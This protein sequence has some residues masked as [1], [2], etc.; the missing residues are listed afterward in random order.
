M[1][2]R[3]L[4]FMLCLIVTVGNAVYAKMIEGTCKNGAWHIDEDGTLTVNIFGDMADYGKGKAPWYN[5]ANEI[6]AI[7]I[8]YNCTNIGR[9]AFYG[10]NKVTKVTGGE[11]VEACAMYSFYDVRYADINLPKCRYVGD[12]AFDDTDRCK[13]LS[14]PSVENLNYKSVYR[15]ELVDIGSKVKDIR[16]GTLEYVECVFI[17]NP[18]P[19]DWS[20]LPTWDEVTS[21]DRYIQGYSSFDAWLDNDRDKDYP[22]SGCQRV[23]V[24]QEYLN[25]YID[26]YPSKH[27]EVERGYVAQDGKLVAGAPIYNDGCLI[28]GWYV[29]D[30]ELYVRI[31]TD[32]MTAFPDDDD[33]WKDV[34]GKVTS[35]HIEFNRMDGVKIPDDAFNADKNN[36]MKGIKKVIVKGYYGEDSPFI[37]GD[38]AFKN[39]V[40]LEEVYG[41]GYFAFGS[42]S[43]AGCKNLTNIS[44]IVSDEPLFSITK[45]GKSCFEG[46]EKLDLNPDGSG[47]Y[48]RDVYIE[49][50]I[51]VPSRAF[52]GCKSLQWEIFRTAR[53]SSIGDQA[54]YGTGVKELRGLYWCPII[55]QES[56]A[57]CD[58]LKQICIDN[59]SFEIGHRAF[60]NCNKLTDIYGTSEAPTTAEDAF[61][62]V[63][64]SKITLHA[65]NVASYL[66]QPN[67]GEMKVDK[68]NAFP[69]YE[70]GFSI[71]AS[72]VLELNKK[73]NEYDSEYAEKWKLYKDYITEVLIKSGVESIKAGWFSGMDKIQRVSVPYSCKSI[74]DE[75]FKGCTNLNDININTVE[76][77]GNNVFEGCSSLQ[78]ISLGLKLQRAG[79]YIFKDCTQLELIEN[80]ENTPAEVTLLTFAEIGS[81][82]Y[83]ARGAVR[84]GLTS[85][86]DGQRNVTLKVPDEFVTNYIVDPNWGKFHI[87]FADSRG[88]WQHAGRFGDGTWIL[89]DDSTMVVAADKDPDDVRWST[90]G[91]TNEV[92]N[93]TKRVEFTGNLTKLDAVFS[94]FPN[95]E[96]VSLSPLI[97]TLE[98]TFNYCEKLRSINLENVT[99]IGDETFIYCSLDTVNLSN[100]KSIGKDAFY[101]CKQ[102]KKVDLSNVSSLGQEAFRGCEQLKTAI[103]GSQCVVG[104]SAF[105][106]CGALVAVNLGDVNLES[107][108]SC[109]QGCKSIRCIVY[110]GSNLPEG[111]FSDCSSLSTVKLGSR[112]R[113]IKWNAFKGCT[114]IDSI[115]CDSPLPPALPAGKWQDI[116]GYEGDTEVQMPIY[117]EEYDVWAFD[118]LDKASVRLFVNPDCIPVYSRF[119]IWKEMTIEGNAEDVEPLLP[120]G[121]SMYGC[122][123]DE[124]G[125]YVMSG[126]SWH[127][128]PDGKM[129]LDALGNIAVRTS[130]KNYWWSEFDSYLP[131]IASVEVTD[132]VTSVPNN[133]FGFMDFERLSRGVNTVTL[134]EGLLKVGYD[135]FGFSGIKDVYIYSEQL[136]LIHPSAF[137]LEAAVANSATL[138]VLKDPEDKYL[139][140]YRSHSATSSF[141]NIVAD[142]EPR[143]P[144]V[145]SV[146]FEYSEVTMHPGD[147]L[148]LEP[149]FLP[150]NVEDK[151]LRYEDVSGG[152]HVSID[153]TGL[154]TAMTEGVAYVEAFSSYTLS[155]NEMMAL[156]GPTEEIYLKITI[157]EP[158]P[159]EEIFYDYKEGEGTEGL[160]I[161]YHQ[162]DDKEHTCEVAGRYDED[163]MTTLAVPENT[164]GIINIP[165]IA[166]GNTVVRIG[167]NAF[168]ELE[169]ITEVRLPATVTQ[170]GRYAF[171]SCYNVKDVYIPVSQPL[172]YTDAYGDVME[173]SMGHNDAFYRVGEDVESGAT[174][175]VPAGSRTAWNIYPW[176]EWFRMIVDDIKMTL[177]GDVNGDGEIGMPDVMFLVNYIL[178]NP[179]ETFNANAADANQDGEIGMPDVMFI[180]QYILNGRFPDEE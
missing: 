106:N 20:R 163:D 158:E 32:Q 174:L 137:N 104:K 156:W 119:D 66:R 59:S 107:A 103:L 50:S 139:N 57:N 72:G 15:C 95:L 45:L 147:T 64:L 67:W 49:D 87:T 97:K 47:S 141:P 142:L 33:L 26:F 81:S 175:H 162:L 1:N 122:G 17:Q 52:Y 31:Y 125:N 143:H 70:F 146:T 166:G 121:G 160:T 167:A 19:P 48:F 51:S 22:F 169:G 80:K 112:V 117:G 136:L 3:R 4:L 150:D 21:W 165:E 168:Y 41:Y 92:C 78:Y 24:P 74:G 65:D 85:S 155:G 61:E 177:R 94:T 91:F 126:S 123:K 69:V 151:T 54:F 84:S 130:S 134:G 132:S 79:D 108:T 140:Y 73:I 114:A 120:T 111:I 138:H 29:E 128:D 18:I 176:N 135:S 35:M 34:I 77:L 145:Q 86:S 124:D 83:E 2:I 63:E 93:K 27:P 62:G 154:I 68:L 42:E 113:S 8:G 161:T 180:V 14:L 55:G 13:N 44:S 6:K 25:T 164:I 82:A 131:F 58:F 116:I 56:F 38:R 89:Y 127:L 30:N 9:F 179:A 115:Y 159:G 148:R 16:P 11:N 37:F 96:S 5:Y 71:S 99:A 178:G 36:L 40:D 102:L 105:R 109:F 133:L 28:G 100:V 118:D 152:Y 23:I 46:C 39:C 149:R 10:L 153:E 173:E 171:A 7:H 90:L 101:C 43:F 60:A 144:K 76:T 170:I 53:L 12:Y 75:A 129:I 172:Q 88:T 157:T 98:G 110:N